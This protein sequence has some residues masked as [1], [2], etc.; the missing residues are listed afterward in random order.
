M[1]ELEQQFN[2]T[3]S[4]KPFGFIVR[5]DGKGFSKF[6]KKY[7]K[8]PYDNILDDIFQTVTRKLVEEYGVTLAYT[9]S[10]EITLYFNTF[11]LQDL[12]FKGRIQKIVSLLSSKTTALFLNELYK[13]NLTDCAQDGVPIFDARLFEVQNIEQV[14]Q[15]FEFRY[16]DCLRNARLNLS[17]FLSKKDRLNK[18]GKQIVQEVLEKTGFNY[19][20][21]PLSYRKGTFFARRKKE[22]EFNYNDQKGI[23]LRTVI[24]TINVDDFPK[25]LKDFEFLINGKD[26]KSSN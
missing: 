6:T 20:D 4:N 7:F 22:T 11:S 18:S 17:I 3:L 19:F 25:D 26:E 1:K 12:Y 5:L 23:V 13:R 15:S 8:K 21:L 14:Q 24:E 10:D 16:F 2:Y 9:Q